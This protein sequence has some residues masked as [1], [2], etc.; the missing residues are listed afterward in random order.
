MKFISQYNIQAR[1]DKYLRM[2]YLFM[3][4]IHTIDKHRKKIIQ[5]QN[6]LRQLG[7]FIYSC[8]KLLINVRKIRETISSILETKYP[9]KFLTK[10]NVVCTQREREKEIYLLSEN[11]GTKKE[12]LEIEAA[13]IKVYFVYWYS[14][15]LSR[16]IYISIHPSIYL[17]SYLNI[18]IYL[19][20]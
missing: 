2:R 6:Q 18:S 14:I 7:G 10:K 16:F 4:E 1:T 5:L 19:S 15:Y 20:G 11:Q 8:T 17:L 9:Y 12:K 3:L 13:E